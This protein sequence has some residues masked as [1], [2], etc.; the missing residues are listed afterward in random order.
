MTKDDCILITGGYG[1][2]GTALYSYLI[3]QGF[4]NVIRIGRGDCDLLNRQATE[5]FFQ[6][7]IA[8]I[9]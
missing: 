3:Y 4:K 5:V 7:T 9:M 6:K 1:L 8:N 2:V